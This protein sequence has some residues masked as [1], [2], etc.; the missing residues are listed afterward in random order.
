VGVNLRINAQLIAAETDAHVWA[1]RFDKPITSLGEGQDDIVAHIGS[2]LGVR[3][4]NLD[5]ARVARSQSGSAAA[6]DLV[7]RARSVLNDPPSRDRAII[8]TG[9]YMQAL[10]ADPTSVPAM[11]GA[12]A[13]LAGMFVDR[14]S[15]KRASELAAAAEAKAP[16]SPD[17]IAAKFLLLQ[18]ERRTQEALM[19]YNRLLDVNPSITG[20]ILQIGLCTCWTY[21][22]DALVPLQRTI[23]L[24]P[25]SPNINAL[26]TS[27]AYTLILWGHTDEAIEILEPLITWEGED[28]PY[29]EDT[30]QSPGWKSQV[31]LYLAIAYVRKS[32][33]EEARRITS[34]ALRMNDLRE[35]TVRRWLRGIGSYW[36]A[37]DIARSRQMAE[38]LRVAG[39][40]DHLDE[41]IDSGVPSTTEIREVT[42]NYSP[43]PMSVPGGRTL[44]TQDVMRLLANANRPVILTTSNDMLTIPGTIYVN[45]PISG[46]LKD[47]WQPRIQRL[48]HELTGSDKDWPVLVFSY[49]QNRW[50]SR[51]FALRL[52]ALGYTNVNWYRGGWEA[53]EASGQPRAPMASRR[54]L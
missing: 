20:L 30:G 17:V 48:M 23:R 35:F 33:L 38:E 8:A 39:V 27:Y 4:V 29:D 11:A 26:K 14:E 25:R 12:A 47:D 31:K 43:T 53:W 10:R 21:Q 15:V 34:R 52:I 3:L 6:F 37:E 7:L 49:N 22:E 32:R 36:S 1:E 44:L 42:R 18:R 24:N 28:A 45:M 54:D 50:S 19:L 40:P 51:N 2:A 16:D 9:L 13:M 5:A 46:S 41:T